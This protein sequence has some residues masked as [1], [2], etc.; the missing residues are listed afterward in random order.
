MEELVV[1]RT[2]LA[3]PER[4]FDAWTDPRQLR[5]WWG[6]EG[7]ECT[8]AH[9]DLRKGGAF[10]IGNRR[11]D[12]SVLFISGEFEAIER[13]TLLG[14]TWRVGDEQHLE[15]VVVSFDKQG[16]KTEV[17]VRHTR[18]ISAERRDQH[19]AGWVGCLDSLADYVGTRTV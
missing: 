14:F 17:V 1:R 4:L 15:R 11:P 7:I 16:D 18:V 13:P 19:R 12:G 2:I 5:E 9:V 3:T 6:P 8:E 10:R